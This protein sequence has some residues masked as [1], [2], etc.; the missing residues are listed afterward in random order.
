M[1]SN[2]L[3]RRRQTARAA[4]WMCL[5]DV[6]IW[7]GALAFSAQTDIIESYRARPR[8]WPALGTLKTAARRVVVLGVTHRR[9]WLNVRERPS[10]TTPNVFRR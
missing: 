3:A 7:H 10:W 8:Q 6:I 1:L 2:T 9:H 5:G 4:P